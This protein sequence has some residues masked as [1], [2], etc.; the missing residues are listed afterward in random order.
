MPAERF[1]LASDDHLCVERVEAPPYGQAWGVL[2]RSPNWRWILPG[3]GGVQWRSGS[4]AL[5]V[6]ELTAFHLRRGDAYQLR[7]AVKRRH[8]VVS[9]AMPGRMPSDTRAWLVAPR[10]LLQLKLAG[11]ELGKGRSGGAVGAVVQQVLAK[12]APIRGDGMPAAVDRAR[13]FIAAQPAGHHTLEEI[14]EAAHC[15]P[16]HLARLFGRHLGATPH[17]YRLRLRLAFA[18]ARLEEGERDLAGLAHDLG[19]ASQSHFGTVFRREAGLTPAQARRALA[20]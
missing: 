12:A 15:S 17:Q 7:H 16:Y 6:D 10:G 5:L 9:T 14:G 8:L 2:H 3:T 11:R 20:G 18:L 4:E 1:V 13:R 19:F